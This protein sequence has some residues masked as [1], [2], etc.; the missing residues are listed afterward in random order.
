MG[1]GTEGGEA[2]GAAFEGRCEGVGTCVPHQAEMTAAGPAGLEGNPACLL[3]CKKKARVGG[4]VW[5]GGVAGTP[6]Q[7]PLLAECRPRFLE[8]TSPGLSGVS[9]GFTRRL[10]AWK[11][12]TGDSS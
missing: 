1:Y 4:R 12:R 11:R 2:V 3:T 8:G 6:A 10:S 9:S 5:R 7:R